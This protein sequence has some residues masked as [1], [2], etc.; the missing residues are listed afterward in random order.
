MTARRIMPSLLWKLPSVLLIFQST[1]HFAAWIVAIAQRHVIIG[2]ILWNVD[3]NVVIDRDAATWIST[4]K[5]GLEVPSSPRGWF[6][7]STEY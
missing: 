2:G 1:T 5:C 3:H 4:K 7:L 6:Y